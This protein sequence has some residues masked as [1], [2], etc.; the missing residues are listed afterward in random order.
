MRE[1]IFIQ[2]Y[3]YSGGSI[4][5][6]FLREFENANCL[7]TEFDLCRHTG[8]IYELGELIENSSSYV[9]D[10]V[11]RNT[12][13]LLNF[14]ETQWP[15]GFKKY[16]DEFLNKLIFAKIETDTKYYGT[17]TALKF[18]SESWNGPKN[19]LLKTIFLNRYNDKIRKL[20]YDTG[21]YH[22]NYLSKEEY[23]GI[24]REFLEDIFN[25]YPEDKKIV[26]YHALNTIGC[27]IDA[28][29][30]YWNNYK[31]VIVDKDPR[32]I[33]CTMCKDSEKYAYLKAFVEPGNFIKNYKQRR[34]FHKE[35]LETLKK[36]R[37]VF[38]PCEDFIFEYD[39]T[40]DLLCEFLNLDK[41]KHIEKFKYFNP[42]NS[43]KN[44]G[45]YKNF[46]DQR[47]ISLVEKECLPIY[48][49]GLYD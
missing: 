18:P 22:L 8:G 42:E 44:V 19:R 20:N 15:K 3:G 17:T 40:S 7:K 35:N 34:K 25:L 30:K 21:V 2:G 12:T 48:E 13:K 9:K 32:D 31:V 14:Y 5:G 16:S 4:V 38:L 1:K 45:I 49:K 29:I 27:K 46:K 39:K 41:T 37:G 47:A 43:A 6:D 24:A 28:Q 11:I 36:K 23:T 26:L 33:Y 10:N